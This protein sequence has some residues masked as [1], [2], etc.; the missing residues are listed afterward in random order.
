MAEKSEY[1]LRISKAI[2][3]LSITGR[4]FC[5]QCG[6]NDNFLSSPQKD[7]T[8]KQLVPILKLFPQINPYY[9]LL[10][11]GTPLIDE[12]YVN[13][14]MIGRYL[15]QSY[16]ELQ[17][18]ARQLIQENTILKAKLERL[19]TPDGEK[20]KRLPKRKRIEL[21]ENK[22]CKSVDKPSDD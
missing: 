21:P 17:I 4:Q 2:E 16:S 13:E 8:T 22:Q 14:G 6:L 7:I 1:Q 5:L 11:E 19:T 9:I 12:K 15:L 10:G 18:E 20:K 3:D